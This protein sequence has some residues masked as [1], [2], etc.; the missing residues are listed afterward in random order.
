VK[1]GIR[2]Q[3]VDAGNWHTCGLTT[4]GAAYC[5]GQVPGSATIYRL[6]APVEGG[7][8]F[9]QLNADWEHTCGVTTASVGYCWGYN[10]KGQLGDGT[11]ENRATPVP[12]ASPEE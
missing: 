9:R 7:L 11:T 2:F 6:P 10:F 4:N 5:W 12:V 1:G 3:S 8:V